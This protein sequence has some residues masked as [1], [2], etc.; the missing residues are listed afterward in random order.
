M[1]LSDT[2][3]ALRMN[4]YYSLTS[5]IICAVISLSPL[6]GVSTYSLTLNAM[7]LLSYPYPNS[8]AIDCSHF[9]C[10]Y[11]QLPPLTLGHGRHTYDL[12]S[13]IET[14]AFR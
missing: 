4:P 8:F 3:L 14:Q 7:L 5:N 9:S 1:C 13:N 12:F 2:N 10:Q 11:I 6:E